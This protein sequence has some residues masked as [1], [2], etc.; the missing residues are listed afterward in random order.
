MEQINDSAL[1][2]AIH[3]VKTIYEGRPEYD[4]RAAL[5]AICFYAADKGIPNRLR[6]YLLVKS[7]ERPVRTLLMKNLQL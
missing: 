1:L 2:N 4:D 3:L 6:K 5:L 7:P